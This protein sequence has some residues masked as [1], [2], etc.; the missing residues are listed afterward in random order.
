MTRTRQL[1]SLDAV[2]LAQL[3]SHFDPLPGDAPVGGSAADSAAL[4]RGAGALRSVLPAAA[5]ATVGRPAARPDRRSW[6]LVVAAGAGLGR[7]GPDPA[8]RLRRAV[9]RALLRSGA[10]D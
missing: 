7:D 1:S 3:T 9:R 6:P 5:G 10:C 8:R 4:P 2:T